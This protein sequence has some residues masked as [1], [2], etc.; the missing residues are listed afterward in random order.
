MSSFKSLLSSSLDRIGY[1]WLWVAIS[2]ILLAFVI[3]L[4]PAKAGAYLWAVSKIAAGGA[5]G[6]GFDCAFFRG[7]DPATLEGIER[8][9][10]QARRATIV[11][12][13]II[14]VGLIG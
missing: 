11:A 8:S 5:L 1:V 3:P 10:A 14:G 9:M 12:A 2:L 13:A 6:Y 7:G 4:N